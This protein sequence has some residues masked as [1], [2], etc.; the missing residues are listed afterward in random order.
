MDIHTISAY[1]TTASKFFGCLE[2]WKIDLAL[3]VRLKNTNQLAGFTKRDDLAYFVKRLTGAEYKHDLL[4]APAPNLRE[5]N[6]I[7]QFFDRYGDKRSV[8]LVGTA[9][10]A[11]RSHAEVLKEMLE[12]ALD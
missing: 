6:A 8:A 4:F 1:E 9:T 5:R 7:E 10:R 12:E 11:R 3:D 2:E